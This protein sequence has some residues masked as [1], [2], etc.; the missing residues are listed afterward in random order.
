MKKYMF[1]LAAAASLAACSND[2]SLNTAQMVIDKVYLEDTKATDGI[3]DRE[4][5]FARLGQTLRIEGSGF[6]GLK[7]IYINGYDNYFNNA[8]MTDN[9]VWVTLNSNIPVAKA[10]EDVRNKITFTKDAGTTTKEFAIRASSPVITGINN[11]LPMPG[12]TVKVTGQNLENTTKVVLPDSTVVT[13]ITSDEDGEWFTFKMPSG[14]ASVGGS[15]NTEGV[16]GPAV[17]PAMFNNNNCYI[18]NFDGKG[19]QGSWSATFGPDD[20]VDDPLNSGRGKVIKI[21]P[22]SYLADNPTGVKAGVSNIKGFYTA[23]NDDA[24]DDWSRMTTYIPGTTP[25]DSVALQFDVYCPEVWTGTGQIEFTLQNNLSN[26]GLGSGCT[27][28]NA[29]YLNQAY[30]WVP[31]FDRE[32]GKISEYKTEGWQ[33]VTIPLS[34]FGNYT[35]DE[36]TWTFQNVIDDKNG[37]S[38][39]NLGVLFC[40][41][42]ISWTLDAGTVEIPSQDINIPIYIDNLRIVPITTKTI[43]D[44]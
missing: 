4:V 21:I 30:A 15:L 37:G 23:G 16:N 26:Y 27:K 31:W 10:T 11:T 7:H 5:T 24:D 42:D 28:Y 38:Y 12:E 3:T 2:D 14:V 44:F 17:S 41:P 33:T 1:F 35:N 29:D 32:T 36:K 20:L 6:T 8:L 18:I 34:S 19:T 22:D 39:R 13:D 25:V 43:S 40:N 9:N